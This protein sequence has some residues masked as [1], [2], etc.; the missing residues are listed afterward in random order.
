MALKMKLRNLLVLLCAVL[1][2]TGAAL[3]FL[4]RPQAIP[5]DSEIVAWVSGEPVTVG[6]FRFELNMNYAAVL[7]KA[8]NA[9]GKQGKRFW[10]TKISGIADKPVTPLEMLKTAAMGTSERRKIM[11]I[12]A[13]E[14]GLAA[15]AGGDISWN[16]FVDSF[17]KENLRRKNAASTNAPVYGPNQFTRKIFYNLD[18]SETEFQLKKAVAADYVPD[19]AELQHLYETDYRPRTYNPGNITVEVASLP[20]NNDD[21]LNTAQT[22]QNA[23]SGGEDMKGACSKFGAEY[24]NRGINLIHLPAMGFDQ[25]VM[26]AIMALKPGSVTPVLEQEDSY[27]IFRCIDRQGEKYLSFEQIKPDIIRGLTDV[28][29]DKQL[30]DRMKDALR[31]NEKVYKRINANFIKNNDVESGQ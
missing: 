24:F 28:E 20:K 25:P 11:Q 17:N 13:K 1:V 10:D 9:G 16:A 27:L 29:F 7:T 23:V 21:S 31:I 3:V 8:V 5:G 4:L 30:A 15:G 12:W 6:E 18:V 14:K 26:A 2:V 22:L 19:E